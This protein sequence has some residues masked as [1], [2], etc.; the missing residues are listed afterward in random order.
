MRL[1]RVAGT[2]LFFEPLGRP[3]GRFWLLLLEIPVNTL[4]QPVQS[5]NRQHTRC[6]VH[7]HVVRQLRNRNLDSGVASAPE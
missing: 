5:G 4:Q 1:V 2:F 3:R 7:P 6:L